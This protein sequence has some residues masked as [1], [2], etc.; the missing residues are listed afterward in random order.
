VQE[1]DE[2][3]VHYDPMIAK[4]CTH[5]STREAAIA[6]MAD[7]LD[8]VIVSGIRH[9]VDF[10]S[11]LMHHARFREGRLST[12]FIAEEYPDGFRGRPLGEADKRRFVAAAAIAKLART[13]RAGAISGTLNGPRLAASAFTAE[14]AG[15]RFDITDAVLHEGRFFAPI[16]GQPYA[17]AS[18]WQPGL[19][20]LHLHDGERDHAL[21]IARVA[22]G[23][24]LA[25]GGMRARVCVR[26]PRAAELARF[27]PK[28]AAADAS[29][30][31]VCPMP[32]LV[33]SVAV[34]VGQEV[35]TG[36]AL[37]VVEAMKMENVLRAERD[38][39]IGKINVKDGD[40]LALNDVIL[41][42]A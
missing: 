3:T 29:K 22:G 34:T 15:E 30:L 16:A 40:N 38:G 8:E 27:M 21:Q 26:S 41:E 31:L 23:Y 10:L 18:D 17:A 33:V 32:G 37:A 2:V 7:A 6:A 9:N 14:I 19:E 5:A 20:I 36:E 28:K 42:F 35:K 24:R 1:G 12:S 11:A 13:Q 25:Q 4:L 39:K